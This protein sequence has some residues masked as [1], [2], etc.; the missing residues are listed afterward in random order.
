MTDPGALRERLAKIRAD[1]YAWVHEEFAE[2]LNSVAAPVVDSSRAVIAAVHV[3]GP[4]Y[5][6]PSSGSEGE[7][8]RQVVASAARIADR[9]RGTG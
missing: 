8:G 4:S 3:H 7:T 2:G 9:A 5:R 1:R 6:F